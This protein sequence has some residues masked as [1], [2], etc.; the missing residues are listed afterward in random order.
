MCYTQRC[1]LQMQN[2]IEIGFMLCCVIILWLVF[3]ES[4]FLSV[5]PRVQ[6]IHD[7]KYSSPCLNFSLFFRADFTRCLL[8]CQLSRLRCFY[9]PPFVLI[10][11]EYKMARS[12]TEQPSW[13]TNRTSRCETACGVT[14][15]LL[16]SFQIKN[17]YLGILGQIQGCFISTGLLFCIILCT[18]AGMRNIS[19]TFDF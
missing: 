8:E 9:F 6:S 14:L 2:I 4:S 15:S 5:Y 19:H 13:E 18:M 12:E 16:P 11:R 7:G 10:F 3:R 1:S 17:F